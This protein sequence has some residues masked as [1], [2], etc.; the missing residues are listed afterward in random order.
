VSSP[1]ASNS[2]NILYGVSGSGAANVWAVGTQL[3]TANATRVRTLT[4]H[5]TG[6]KWSVVKSA[7]A[8]T[9]A[10]SLYGVSVLPDKTAWAVGMYTGP[11]GHNGLALTEH[12]NGSTWTA[13]PAPNPGSS[14]NMLYSVTAVN[15]SDVWAVGGYRGSDE[16]FHPLIEHWN[17]HDWSMVNSGLRRDHG[18]LTSVSSSK[19][20]GVWA[21]GQLAMGAPDPQVV[22]HLVGSHWVLTDESPVRSGTSAAGSAYPQSVASSAA[23]PWL[24]GSDRSGNTGFKTLV[25]GPGTHGR[26]A[27]LASGNPTPQ[28]NYLESIVTVGSHAWAAGYSL[29]ASSGDTNPLFEF[30]SASGAW[31]I[32]PTINPGAKNGGTTFVNSLFAVSSS[33]IWAVGSY[34]SAANGMGTLIM[35]YTGA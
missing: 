1:N 9:E 29:V 5:Y 25:E 27:E 33:N 24:A 20:G 22:L 14:D 2:D 4:L 13:L 7:N 31:K 30:G 34:S 26:P 3:P 10:N 35:H 23:G 19:A 17:G 21:T 28:D 12:W 16:V 32:V 6:T 18:Y 11:T 8:G 15:D